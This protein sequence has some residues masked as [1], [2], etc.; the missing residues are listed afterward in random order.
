MFFIKNLFLFCN[1]NIFLIA[2]F[3]IKDKIQ[4][5]RRNSKRLPCLT[6]LNYD[7]EETIYLNLILHEVF[8]KKYL[9]LK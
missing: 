7:W 3:F 9:N 4:V 1:L 5:Y 2:C 6:D 8:F